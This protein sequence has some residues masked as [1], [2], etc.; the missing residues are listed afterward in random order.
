[1][2][3]RRRICPA[4]VV[5]HVVNRAAKRARLFDH[6][7]D[8]HAF[9]RILEAAVRRFGVQLFAYCVM[10]N[11]WHFLLTTLSEKSLPRCMHWLTTTHARRWQSLRAMD[12]NGAVYQ[13]RYKAIPISAER[14][15]WVC[16]YVERNALRANLV[17]RAEDWPWSSLRHRLERRE[18]S[19]L[20]AWPL[21]EPVDWIAQVN[22]P[23]TESELDAF[24]RAMRF[25][26]PFAADE[27]SRGQ[28][29]A[30]VGMR[31]NAK[32]GRPARVSVLEK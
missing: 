11:H 12:G 17:E 4:G 28:L 22:K 16:R 10:P 30:A 5:F 1:M 2:P 18:S 9:E 25:G 8:Y 6:P 20:T 27:S 29:A 15:L 23:Q 19:W 3:R 14:F 21:A 32:R 26:E 24:R 31:L 13:G 7:A